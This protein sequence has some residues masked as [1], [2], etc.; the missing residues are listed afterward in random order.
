MEKRQ[1]VSA[2]VIALIASAHKEI[3]EGSYTFMG[4]IFQMDVAAQIACRLG[5]KVSYA[6]GY[7]YVSSKEEYDRVVKY[8]IENHESGYSHYLS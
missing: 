3:P 1:T 4:D 6:E 5:I 8:I 7:S 2:G